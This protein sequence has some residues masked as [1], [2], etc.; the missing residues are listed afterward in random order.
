MILEA[1]TFGL[2]ADHR[3][4]ACATD[5][6]KCSSF[7]KL[8]DRFRK[9]VF[10]RFLDDNYDG[11]NATTARNT[12]T[13]PW[14]Q[15]VD[16]ENPSNSPLAFYDVAN[17]NPGVDTSGVDIL[18]ES[19]IPQTFFDNASAALQN[20]DFG[21]RQFLYPWGAVANALAG[22]FNGNGSVEQGDLDLVLN[23]WGGPRGNWDNAQGF[24]SGPV[25][26]E[27]L[28]AVLNGW[29][30]SSLAG[31]VREAGAVP[32]PAAMLGVTG[33]AMLGLCGRRSGRDRR[34]G[35]SA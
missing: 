33:L 13:N 21:G 10:R 31:L 1:K 30:A 19:N 8:F 6:A 23:N 27:E 20:D 25:D 15:L 22:D 2:T 12:L 14:A 34:T 17:G 28:D 16:V 9:V 3:L 18:M 5:D 32:E 4:E 35:T 29:G 26:Q 7:R 24:A 11:T